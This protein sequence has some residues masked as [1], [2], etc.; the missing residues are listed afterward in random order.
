MTNK[1][2]SFLA[3]L[4]VAIVASVAYAAT[5]LGGPPTITVTSITASLGGCGS[6]GPNEPLACIG[7]N[8]TAA[9]PI[10]GTTLNGFKVTV[11]KQGATPVVLDNLPASART[12]LVAVSATPVV[13]TGT[14]TAVVTAKYS[15]SLIA[16]KAGNF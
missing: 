7:V 2:Y 9:V 11:T 4:L 5:Q 8:W 3:L 14:F 15:S 16:S 13:P 6:A 10:K 1:N 12:A